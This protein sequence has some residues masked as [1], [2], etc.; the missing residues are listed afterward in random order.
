MICEDRIGM[1]TDAQY[2][3]GLNQQG[4]LFSF[5]QTNPRIGGVYAGHDLRKTALASEWAGLCFSSDGRW[6][7]VNL[8]RPG[9]TIAIT[10]PWQK[11]P[12]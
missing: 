12:V 1:S 11:G 2:I 5:C 10:G 8:Y 7:F 4:G 9:M 6:M 3:A